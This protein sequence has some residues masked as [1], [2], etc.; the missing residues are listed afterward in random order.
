[1][2]SGPG[3]QITQE[4]TIDYPSGW[5]HYEC[6]TAV[7]RGALEMAAHELHDPTRVLA[8]VVSYLV[9]R[10]SSDVK[11]I[12]VAEKNFVH[13]ASRLLTA[14]QQF[15]EHSKTPTDAEVKSS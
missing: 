9:D 4:A 13:A 7:I 8:D 14:Y 1:M 10:N 12:R 2:I 15:Q 6:E 11:T 3:F 5:T